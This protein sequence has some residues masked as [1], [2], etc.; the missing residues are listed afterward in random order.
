MQGVAGSTNR[1]A[2]CRRRSAGCR[3]QQSSQCSVSQ[4][5]IIAVQG[6]AGSRQG[7]AREFCLQ[8]IVAPEAS[9]CSN[10]RPC[11]IHDSQGIPSKNLA[12]GGRPPLSTCELA[13]IGLWD[14]N[15][16]GA[17]GTRNFER[18]WWDGSALASPLVGMDPLCDDGS[19]LCTTDPFCVRRI[20]S[21]YN[22]SPLGDTGG[23]TT[24]WNFR[25]RRFRSFPLHGSYRPK[26][27]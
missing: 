20:P 12:R 24:R 16:R 13:A 22:G 17:Q 8:A 21:V 6:V 3:R 19:P 15:P 11:L 4:A 26:R 1:S 2:G 14:G 7:V 25:R 5:V 18:A 9:S 27:R 23:C 10:L